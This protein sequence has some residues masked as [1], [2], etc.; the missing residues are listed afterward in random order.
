MAHFFFKLIPPRPTFAQ[1]MSDEE[2]GMMGEHAAYVR[3]LFDKGTVLAYGPVF[4]AD[5]SFGIGLLETETLQ[6]AQQLADNDPTV[7]SGL[8]T[9]TLSPMHVAASQPSRVNQ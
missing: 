2:R 3:S 4:D 6:Q 1:D 9:Y 8:S 7:K 5:G